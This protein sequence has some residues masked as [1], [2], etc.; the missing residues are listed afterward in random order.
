M[1]KKYKVLKKHWFEIALS[2][3]QLPAGNTYQPAENSKRI[4]PDSKTLLVTQ[5]FGDSVRGGPLSPG[6]RLQK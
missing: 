3:I 5:I 2:N 1:P 6:L 4:L